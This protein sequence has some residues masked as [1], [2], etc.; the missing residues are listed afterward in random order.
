MAT[1]DAH[2]LWLSSKVPNDQLLLYVFDGAPDISAG[3]CRLRRNAEACH[4]LRLRVRDDGGRGYPRWEP[5]PVGCEQFLIH[6]AADGPDN[7]TWQECLDELAGLERL[8][9]S[10]MAW[11]AHVFP[12]RVVVVQMSHALGDGRRSAALAA[13]LLGRG[14]PVAPVADPDPGFLPWRAVVAARAHRRLVRDIRDGLIGPPIPPRPALSVNSHSAPTSVLR[15]VAVDRARLRQP[16]VT[17]GALVAVAEALGGYLAER[18]ED[19][20]R[21]AAEVPIAGPEDMRSHNNFRNVGVDLHPELEP[22]GRAERIARQLD[23]HRRRGRHPAMRASAEAFAAL[24]ASLLRWGVGRFD[25]EVRSDVVTGHTVVSS[26]NRGP[27]DLTFGGCPVVLTAGYPAL[28]PMMGLTHGVHGIGDVVA[29]S[30]HADPVAV[31]VEEYLDRLSF[32]LG[33]APPRL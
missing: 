20:S 32:A 2:L 8:D 15:T 24:P 29:V 14:A 26:V 23:A 27:A 31:D 4:E 25:P 19:T 16:T 21:L 22:V 10:V 9:P 3:L 13:R 18:G 17:V 12:P 7:E 6:P 1:P 28:S 33:C 30:V 5:G 11:R